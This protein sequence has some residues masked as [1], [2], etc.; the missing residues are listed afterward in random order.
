MLSYLMFIFSETRLV[1][2]V[3]HHLCTDDEKKVSCALIH[4]DLCAVMIIC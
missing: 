1:E 4:Y 2:I 3:D